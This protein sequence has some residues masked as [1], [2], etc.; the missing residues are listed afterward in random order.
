[1]NSKSRSANSLR[2]M[3]IGVGSQ[4][5]ILLL[6][7]IGRTVFINVLGAEYLGVNG[8]FANILTILSLA[9][10]GIGNVMIY[11][12]YKPVAE[13]DEA[14]IRALLNYY[15]NIYRKIAVAVLIFGLCVVPFLGK[16]VNSDLPHTSIILYY[17]LFL[18]NSVVS[19]LVVYKSALINADQKIYIIKVIQTLVVLIK[20]VAQIIIL[21]ITKSFILYLCILILSTIINNLILSIKADKLYPF[22]KQSSNLTKV[23]TNAIKENIKAVFIYKIGVIIMNNTDNILISILIGTVY[24]GYYS[25]YSLLVTT[26]GTIVGIIIQALF[27]SIGNLNASGDMVKS[28]NFFNGLLLFFQWLSAFCALSFLLV[29]NDF[30]TIWI[31]EKYLLEINVVLAIVL[32]FYIQNIINPVWMYRETM[33]LFNQIKYLMIIAA[34][35]NLIFSIIL[36]IQWGLAGIIISTA[37]ARLLTT[38]WYEPRLLYRMKFRQPVRGYWIRQIR[39]SFITIIAVYISIVVTKSMP[40]SL[41]YIFVKILIGFIVVSLVFLITNFK[42]EEFKMLSGYAIRILKR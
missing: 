30:I 29:F 6:M 19:Y 26:V 18:L 39:Y 34:I 33:G 4:V 7:F 35:V 20:E 17:I 21:L 15:K 10:L 8:L 42:S 22:L 14:T 11:S 13:N 9:E 25:N 5:I 23:D 40:I 31:G 32:N 38:V 24:V 36:G 28:Y 3:I 1:M 41:T 12:L 16:I 37:I 27:S 2:N